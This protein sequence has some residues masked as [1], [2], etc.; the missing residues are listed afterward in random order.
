M[1]H[2]VLKLLAG[3]L[4]LACSISGGAQA[5]EAAPVKKNGR[6]SAYGEEETESVQETDQLKRKRL[7][8]RS[9]RAGE[10]LKEEN[11]PASEYTIQPAEWEAVE[12][13]KYANLYFTLEIPK[14]WEVQWEGNAEQ[15]F[16]SA[17]KPGSMT[18]L[19]NVDHL[20]APKTQ[21]MAN[22]L[23]MA[24]YLRE[25]TVEEM[26]GKMYA[27]ST[28]HFTVQN[29][30]VPADREELQALRRDKR[31]WDYRALYATFSQDGTPG[32]GIYS[33]VIMEAPDLILGGGYNYAMW[34]INAVFTEFAPLGELVNWQPVLDRIARGL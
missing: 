30:C 24:F 22:L 10:A 20:T 4:V 29:S 9:E 1:R 34:E 19:S 11:A 27:E 16:W 14:G 33:A 17:E 26:F 28:D 2:T 18:G 12:W 21:Q 25:G 7:P 32:E 3:L 6:L 23:G 31:I 13:T 5:G 8:R 15:L